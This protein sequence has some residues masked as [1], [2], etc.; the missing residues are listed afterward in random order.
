[1]SSKDTRASVHPLEGVH[2]MHFKDHYYPPIKFMKMQREDIKDERRV[3][4]DM[5]KLIRQGA[6]AGITLSLC[7]AACLFVAGLAA[8]TKHVTIKDGA[9]I[10]AFVGLAYLC[11]TLSIKQ[12]KVRNDFWDISMSEEELHKKTAFGRN[13]VSL[14]FLAFVAIG[15]VA[16][17]HV[18]FR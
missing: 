5:T 17:Y 12:K 9:C 15:L 7:I 10:V 8:Y 14:L 18:E 1:M 13:M 4:N 6:Y 3:R 2:R 16:F 11:R